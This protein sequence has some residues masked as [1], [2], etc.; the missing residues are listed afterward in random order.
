MKVN[1]HPSEIELGELT[2]ANVVE[3]ANSG[4]VR[5]GNLICDGVVQDRVASRGPIRWRW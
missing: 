2:K 4:A 1:T 3:R 5:L